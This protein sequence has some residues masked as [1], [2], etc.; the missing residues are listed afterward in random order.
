MRGNICGNFHT[1]MDSVNQNFFPEHQIDTGQH[2]FDGEYL[3]IQFHF[4]RFN[5]RE[6]KN[7]IDEIQEVFAA[8]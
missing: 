8:A 7:V 1:D 5:L 2:F 3:Q 6:I 4:A